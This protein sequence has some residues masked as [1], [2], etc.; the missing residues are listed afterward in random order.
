MF[1]VSNCAMSVLKVAKGVGV[2]G[3]YVAGEHA[4]DAASTTGRGTRH[5][6]KKRAP[7]HHHHHQ[8]LPHSSHH[9][10]LLQTSLRSASIQFKPSVS[11]CALL[12]GS[13]TKVNVPFLNKMHKHNSNRGS[14]AI[15]DEALRRHG[16][17]LENRGCR[18]AVQIAY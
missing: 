3:K 6:I 17:Y 18:L 8:R 2:A 14:P 15:Q 9:S 4:I 16:L 10:K 11:N 12:F 1:C 13:R 7:H 5:D